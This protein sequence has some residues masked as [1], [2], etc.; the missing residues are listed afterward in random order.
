MPGVANAFLPGWASMIGARQGPPRPDRGHRVPFLSHVH[1]AQPHAARPGPVFL[2]AMAGL[3]LTLTFLALFAGSGGISGGLGRELAGSY[4]SA[5]RHALRTAPNPASL[6]PGNASFFSTPPPS[7]PPPSPPQPPPPLPS[8]SLTIFAA[9]KPGDLVPGSASHRA[10]QSWLA[11][12]PP[13][14]V[15]LFGFKDDPSLQAAVAAGDGRVS[16]ETA[17]DTN[18]LGVPMFN[19]LIAR[20][21]AA[22]SD[23]SLFVNADIILLDDVWPAMDRARRDGAGWVVTGMRTDVDTFPFDFPGSV[24]EGG[25]GGSGV[26]DDG[27]SGSG[28]DGAAD[29]HAPDDHLAVAARAAYSGL[30]DAIREHARTTGKLHSYGGVDFWAWDN[31][32]PPL[33]HGPFPSFVYGRGKYDNWFMHALLHDG[34]RRVIDATNVVTSIHVAHTYAHVAGHAEGAKGQVMWSLAKKSSFELFANIHLAYATDIGYKN[35]MGTAHH[36]PLQLV[37]CREP[38]AGN[39]C[40]L[41]RVRPASCSCEYSPYHAATM[42]D[43]VLAGNKY[44]CGGVSAEKQADFAAVPTVPTPGAVPGLPHTL[45]QL[46]PQVADARGLVVL[47]G[48]TIKYHTMLM[49][50]ACNLR[51]VGVDN[52]LVA[53]FDDE[54]YQYAFVRGLAVYPALAQGAA[55]HANCDFGTTC[56]RKITKQKSQA[57]LTILQKGYHVLW[58]DMDVVWLQNPIPD[59]W[60]YGPATLPIQGNEPSTTAPAN[61][62]LRINSGFYLA[63]ADEPTIAAFDLITRHALTTDKSEQPSFYIV[64]CGDKGQ[65]RVGTDACLEPTTGVRTEFLPRDRYPNGA[66]KGFW[67]DTTDDAALSDLV[68]LHNNWIFGLANKF[69]RLH[70]RNMWYIGDDDEM[71]C[72]YPWRAPPPVLQAE[73]LPDTA[74]VAAGNDGN[75]HAQASQVT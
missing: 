21:M 26:G 14:R 58:T 46:L 42:S 63:R 41:E 25:G 5:R 67:N 68:V 64:L 52:L 3:A 56:F 1:R 11:L 62:H 10:L 54:V 75:D 19:S 29:T 9:P 28:Q 47:T 15:V 6:A 4:V 51:N 59:L 44:Q 24:G 22:D 23:V 50:F 71:S 39:V 32:G 7:A 35:Q 69:E 53:A 49:N 2:T 33:M 66:Y 72:S 16:L 48:T 40:L 18:F 70:R 12:H 13:A 27:A 45:D 43:P 61:G 65:H 60:A 73:L 17:F 31:S 74:D 34:P 38:A 8:S 30:Y 37:A 20:A 36:I 55:D 57:V